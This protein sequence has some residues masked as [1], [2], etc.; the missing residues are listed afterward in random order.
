MAAVADTVG[1][2]QEGN[3]SEQAR[4][5]QSNS[6]SKRKTHLSL[7]PLCTKDGTFVR[8]Q[9]DFMT[10]SQSMLLCFKR[11]LCPIGLCI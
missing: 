10:H 1:Y 6:W 4:E 8:L 9:N 7:H 11:E 3:E 5:S 2:I